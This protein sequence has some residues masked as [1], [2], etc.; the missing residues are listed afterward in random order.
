MLT[1]IVRVLD[2]GNDGQ[3]EVVSRALDGVDDYAHAMHDVV[4]CG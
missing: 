3:D 1:G 4:P 2:L